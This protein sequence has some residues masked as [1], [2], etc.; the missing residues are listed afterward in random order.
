M[1]ERAMMYSAGTYLVLLSSWV[2]PCA[3]FEVV[4][5]SGHFEAYRIQPKTKQTDVVRRKAFRMALTNWAWLPFALFF[6]H[7]LLQRAFPYE[8]DVSWWRFFGMV[9]VSF[10]VD[11]I[12]FYCYHRVLHEVPFLYLRFHKPHH[13]Y[14]APFAWT[15]HAVHPVEML[16]QSVGAMIGPVFFA[17]PLKYYW[18]WLA[19]RQL[20]G[21]LD[22]TGFDFP[23]EPLGLIP[24][25]GG[26][27]FHD[28][29]H[30]YFKANYASCFSFID[31]MFG[32]DIEAYRRKRKK[33]E[34][35]KAASR[36]R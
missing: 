28:D 13:V 9:I 19:I 6:A 1:D 11:D 15:S 25:V 31:Y 14:T 30:R 29:H 10:L 20:Q 17:M 24:G 8:G 4:D 26:T 32:T 5:R 12:C 33:L 16:L 36:S 18:M 22:H 23:W 21:V 7:P 3:L 34:E 35:E 2:V 27:K